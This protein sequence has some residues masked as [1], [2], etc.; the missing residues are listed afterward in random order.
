MRISPEQAG[1]IHGT[2][3]EKP[4]EGGNMAGKT[5]TYSAV[6]GWLVYNTDT[7]WANKWKPG[8][9][10]PDTASLVLDL[11]KVPIEKLVRDLRNEGY[12]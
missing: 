7:K 8:D 5:V 11:F 6:V 1:E 10:L 3:R 12:G 2:G 4:A 9:K